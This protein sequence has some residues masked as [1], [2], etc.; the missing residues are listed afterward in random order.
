MSI[1]CILHCLQSLYKYM[2]SFRV[3]LPNR[4]MQV[5]QWNSFSVCLRQFFRLLLDIWFSL[6]P[7]RLS[8][9]L[10]ETFFSDSFCAALLCLV[11]G[12]LK[13][14][15]D[16]WIGRQSSKDSTSD[17]TFT[18]G[19]TSK[20]ILESQLHKH[21][22]FSF[23]SVY[24]RHTD[25]VTNRKHNH[26]QPWVI[27][28]SGYIIIAVSSIPSHTF[29]HSVTHSHTRTQTEKNPQLRSV[30]SLPTIRIL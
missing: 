11:Y 28:T 18:V 8:A 25:A 13:S 27:R 14:K 3:C 21:V 4:L 1:K 15:K 9:L 10:P 12:G 26:I 16:V 2:F 6:P 7:S 17:I 5:T 24:H 30:I 20:V 29:S 23:E 19:Y 22:F